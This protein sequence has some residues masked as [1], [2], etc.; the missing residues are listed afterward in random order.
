MVISIK[1]II[2]LVI[3]LNYAI[4]PSIWYLYL[5]ATGNFSPVKSEEPYAELHY[6]AIIGESETLDP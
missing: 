2:S 5:D 3:C 4:I 1:I 6:G